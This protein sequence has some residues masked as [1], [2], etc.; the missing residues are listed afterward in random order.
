MIDST[1]LNWVFTERNTTMAA[2]AD[3]LARPE[4]KWYEQN[5]VKPTAAAA[6]RALPPPQTPPAGN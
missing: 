2:G 5:K 6:S 1:T 4:H 3:I